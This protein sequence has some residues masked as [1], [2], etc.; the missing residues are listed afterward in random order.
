MIDGDG[1]IFLVLI[2][3]QSGNVLEKKTQNVLVLNQNARH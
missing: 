2:L 3:K 1:N